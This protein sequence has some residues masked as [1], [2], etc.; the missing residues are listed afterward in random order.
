MNFAF[1][2]V[3]MLRL[4]RFLRG[5]VIVNFYG[6]NIEK[7]LNAI[8]ANRLSIWD[9]R[10][11]KG[12]ISAAVSVAS[13][14]KLR[15]IKRP[16]KVK[17]RIVKKAG[18][19]F[20]IEKHKNRT[21]FLIGAVLFILLIKFMSSFIW[22][23]EISGNE[24][25]KNSEVKLN[26][27]EIGIVEGI[28]KSKI[29]SKLDA[30]ELMLINENIAWASLNIEGCRLT[31]NI[32]ETRDIQKNESNKPTNIKAS[33]DGIIKKIDVTSGNVLVKPGDAVKKGDILVS[34]I[35]ENL[36]STIFVR[37][38]GTIT[39]QTQ[40]IYQSTQKYVQD[41][42][43]HAARREKRKVLTIFDINIPLFLSQINNPV[44]EKITVSN[45]KLFGA[46][47]PIYITEY[48]YY[49]SNTVTVNYSES[50]L[51]KLLEKDIENKMAL[52]APMSFIEKSSEVEAKKDSLTLT[53][54]FICEENISYTEDIIMG[55]IN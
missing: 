15:F 45:A 8:A 36:N 55:P 43:R 50:E 10:C 6:D 22:I 44:N 19:P 34:G 26:C 49:N 41:V 24:R 35:I 40:R 38:S 48:S 37:S 11:R 30:Q 29:S 16:Y 7:L 1:E 12:F 4:F 3:P 28:R 51:L 42:S 20:F 54:T 39:A 2:V 47:L 13:F 23:V 27:K 14:K 5:Y 17:L 25:I 33:Y 31:V 9:M 18:L 46:K 53:K 52:D 32:S 21:G